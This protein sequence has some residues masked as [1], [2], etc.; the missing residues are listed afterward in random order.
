MAG[1]SVGS[2][3]ASKVASGATEATK[4]SLGPTDV[5]TAF[6]A[7]TENNIP[8]T[9][10]PTP[11]GA[12]GAWVTLQA[13]GGAGG[14]GATGLWT[15]NSG[16]GG[17]GRIART[18]IPVSE[19]GP[20]YSVTQGK[21][22]KGDGGDSTFSS[23]PIT[24]TAKGGKKGSSGATTVGSSPFTIAGGAGGT[25]SVKGMS[26]VL[27]YPGSP[28][29]DATSTVTSP[30]SNNAN[31]AGAGGGAGGPYSSDNT[32]TPGGAGG[33]STTVTGGAGGT[34]SVK[35]GVKPSNSTI[36]DAGAGGG[37]GAGAWFAPGGTG[38]DGG[39]FGGGGGGAGA[40][41][42][43]ALSGKGGDG[44]TKIEWT[45]ESIE[46]I[47]V[48]VAVT[49][50]TQTVIKVQVNGLP[51][52]AGTVTGYN[53]YKNGVKVTP[54]PQS[55]PEYTF[56]A[57]DSNSTYTLTATAVSSGTESSPYDAVTV[58]TLSDGALSLED[59]TAIDNIVATCMAEDNQ[60]GV[61]ISVSG[62]KG[63]YTKAYGVS[64][65]S[66]AITSYPL[67]VN[68]KFRIGSLTKWFLGTAVLMQVDR[69]ILSLNDT[70]EKWIPGMPDG[71]NITI[72]HLLG[73][74]DGLFE[75]QAGNIGILPY[76][77]FMLFFPTNPIS[78]ATQMNIIKSHP[79]NWPSGTN[80]AYHN[81]GMIVLGQ[82]LEAATGRRIRDILKEDIII[83]LGLT[84]TSWPDSANMPEPYTRGLGPGI[85]GMQDWTVVN[86]DYVGCAGALVSTIDNI[87][88]VGQA[89][90]DGWG[91]SPELH[92]Y[93][94]DITVYSSD[95]WP[96]E[97]PSYYGYGPAYFN[98]AGWFGHA[99]SV[100]GYNC[101]CYY[102]PV[103]G[104]VF[105]GMENVQSSGV[106]I[107]SKIQIRICEYLYPGTTTVEQPFDP[108]LRHH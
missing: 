62:P 48:S 24:L 95:V 37:G 56:A 73:M 76:G 9:N 86:P 101:T 5:W 22:G 82:I 10:Y 84:E 43:V 91:I 13:A 29:G 66:P 78:P 83:P 53:F 34:D 67:S 44:F 54:T 104:A 51:P 6:T 32:K 75:F 38:A 2:S 47:R 79:V 40:G 97:G 80:F 55:S 106:A 89:M 16:G 71:R 100:S 74:R 14:E 107:E 77:V 46:Y 103:S 102:D 20:T 72:R 50:V 68:H 99:G 98:I 49:E 30:G 69:G 4:V 33:N 64:P 28:G 93:R 21:G 1:I 45:A 17:G 8:R 70:L 7:I 35:P 42:T 60:P 94:E 105:A 26:G 31:N 57:L 12:T 25:Y 19:M 36:P 108:A 39:M 41:N 27:V 52:D 65:A 63:S 81:S 3:D 92:E 88:R 90:R 15:A 61:M 11:Y 23:G 87:Q 96:Y 58:R 59:R 18:W 85:S